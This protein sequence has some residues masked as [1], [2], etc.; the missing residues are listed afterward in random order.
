MNCEICAKPFN[1]TNRLPLALP[2]CDEAICSECQQ[3]IVGAP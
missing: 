2:C 3:E 1:L